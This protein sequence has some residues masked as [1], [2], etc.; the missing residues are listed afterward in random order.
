MQ[1]CNQF[2]M[3]CKCLEIERFRFLYADI[4]AT[5]CKLFSSEKKK[6]KRYKLYKFVMI[7]IEICQTTTKCF[8]CKAVQQVCL[9]ELLWIWLDAP[10]Q[11]I[12]LSPVS[13]IDWQA[14]IYT[15]MS[16]IS[17]MFRNLTGGWSSKAAKEAAKYGKVNLVLPKVSKHT[18]IPDQ[19]TWNLDKNASYVHYCDNETADG[20]EFPFIPETNGVPIVADMSSNIFSKPFDVTKV[21]RIANWQNSNEQHHFVNHECEMCVF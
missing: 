8:C 1:P 4:Y 11:P 10:A 7:R 3:F 13:M 17:N 12:I 14:T 6:M 5:I 19:S 21:R 16:F 20:V 2:G 18:T 9:L 15:L